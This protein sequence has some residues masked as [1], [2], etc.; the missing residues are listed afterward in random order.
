MKILINKRIN[1]LFLIGNGF[2]LAHGSKTSYKDFI[3]DFWEKEKIKVQTSNQFFLDKENGNYVYDDEILNM[4]TPRILSELPNEYISQNEKG[5]QW[6]KY[7]ITN[8][9]SSKWSFPGV[10]SS[11]VTITVK[12]LF[13][14]NISEKYYFQNWVDIEEEYYRVLKNCLKI[15]NENPVENA[16]N[17]DKLN[18]DFLY[19]SNMLEAYLSSDANVR[20]KKM[21]QIIERLNFVIR[22]ELFHGREKNSE[23]GSILFLNFNYTNTEKEYLN[24]FRHQIIQRVSCIH[25]HG[26]INNPNNPIVFGY[27]DELDEE[28][29]KIENK[30]DNRYLTNVKSMKYIQTSN[31]RNLLNFLE[32]SDYNVYVIG[33]SCGIS[34]RTLLNTI[35][36]HKNCCSIK[37]FY[38]KR[39]DGTDDFNEKIMNI[40]RNFKDKPS[41]RER[42][43]DKTNCKPLV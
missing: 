24:Y 41:M 13:L 40:S 17:V 2:D 6:F 21:P 42:V 26:E 30:N 29:K 28:Y 33:H 3:D 18:D 27:G 20:I 19:V 32:S 35:F 7:L 5:Y 8:S 1:K 10:K 38:H 15:E 14:Q 11:K 37:V 43:I 23:K 12:N 31:Y 16:Y 34:D 4:Q 25:I 22:P 39:K 9:A 36:E